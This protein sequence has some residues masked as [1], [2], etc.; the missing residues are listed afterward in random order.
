MD[1]QTGADTNEDFR[2]RLMSKNQV[3]Q[4]MKHYKDILN[5]ALGGQTAIPEN[6]KRLL[7]EQLLAVSWSAKC[8][9]FFLE[10]IFLDPCELKHAGNEK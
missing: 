6:T 7:L 10:N 2:V 5:E 3:V 4:H 8:S 1:T 9:Q